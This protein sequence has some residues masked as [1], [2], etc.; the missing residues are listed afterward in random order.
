MHGCTPRKQSTYRGASEAP[1]SLLPGLRLLLGLLEEEEVAGVPIG[2]NRALGD[3]RAYGT[4]RFTDVA[5]V[6]KAA[7]T[8]PGAHFGEA[9]GESAGLEPPQPHLAEARRIHQP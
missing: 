8:E 9:F 1:E 3:C 2:M 4:P 5:A 7:V 6:L